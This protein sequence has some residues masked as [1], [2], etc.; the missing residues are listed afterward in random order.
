MNRCRSQARWQ[1]AHGR[2]LCATHFYQAAVG[3]GASS[4]DW[5]GETNERLDMRG[6]LR[7]H[8]EEWT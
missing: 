4:T 2:Y 5:V 8:E 3:N 1:D 7:I 6:Y